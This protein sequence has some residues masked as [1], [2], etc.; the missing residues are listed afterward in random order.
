MTELLLQLSPVGAKKLPLSPEYPRVYPYTQMVNRVILDTFDPF[1]YKLVCEPIADILKLPPNRDLYQDMAEK[2]ADWFRTQTQLPIFIMWSGGIDSSTAVTAFLQT[3]SAKELERVNIVASHHGGMEFPELWNV[4]VEVF[5]PAR[6]FP[7]FE[8]IEKYTDAGIVITGE[9]GD[10]VF[11]SDV[12]K[13]VVAHFGDEGIHMPYRQTMPK[14]YNK[15]FGKE[16]GPMFFERYLEPAEM[17]PFPLQSSFDWVWWFN[18]TNKWQHVKYRML[19]YRPW[20]NPRK[21]MERIHHFFD[22]PEWQ[23]WSIDNHDKKIGKTIESYKLAAKRYIVNVTGFQDYMTKPK[24]GSL[25]KIWAKSGFYH[26][27]S[28]DMKYLTFKEVAE[29]VR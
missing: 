20:R 19:A 16:L 11:G 1:H 14:I 13:Q 10:Q 24:V 18:F 2:R 26:G 9:L 15:L 12:I 5:G 4:I 25:N 8:P 28:T 21:A 3:W 22:T 17:A 23:R 6:I 27:I 29:F 7:S